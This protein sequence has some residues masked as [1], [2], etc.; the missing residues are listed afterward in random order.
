MV[1][2]NRPQMPREPGPSPALEQRFQRMMPMEPVFQRR[3]MEP[4]ATPPATATPAAAASETAEGET[5]ATAEPE[6]PAEGDVE[7]GT[8]A[9]EAETQ[10]TAAAVEEITPVGEVIDFP[11]VAPPT[12]AAK[13]A[14][15]PPPKLAPYRAPDLTAIR[16]P[17]L[18]GPPAATMA[19]APEVLR[20]TG[21]TPS[22]HHANI[23]T[24]LFRV[25]E[26]AR[27][28]QR[29]MVQSIDS[30]ATGARWSIEAM[31]G[32]VDAIV[33]AC[34]ASV[35][36]AS[37]AALAEVERVVAA[38]KAD[39]MAQTTSGQAAM[40]ERA[41]AVRA[42]VITSLTQNGASK[43][44][45]AH[46][47]LVA[48]YDS[49]ADQAATRLPPMATGQKP[50]PLPGG[51][52]ATPDKAAPA[53]AGAAPSTTYAA[54]GVKVAAKVPTAPA[55]DSDLAYRTAYLNIPK[56][57]IIQPTAKELTAAWLKAAKARAETYK[58]ADNHNRFVIAAL[59]LVAPTAEGMNQDHEAF[60]KT[61]DDEAK[62]SGI[63]MTDAQA[64]AI[65]GIDTTLRGPRSVVNFF[66]PGNPDSMPFKIN[67]GLRQTGDKIKAAL[68]QQGLEVESG[69]RAGIA[70]MAEAYP[71]VLARLEE[72]LAGDDL[73]DER[74]FTPRVLQAA[75]S[76]IALHDGQIGQVRGN[77]DATLRQVR[78]SFQGQVRGLWGAVDDAQAGILEQKL[79]AVFHFVLAK[80]LYTGT[81]GTDLQASL[82]M[83]AGYAET[84]ARAM[85]APVAA[86]GAAGSV[87]QQKAAD[88]FNAQLGGEWEG[89]LASVARLG[90]ELGAD[91]EAA[92][93]AK[94]PFA[95][96]EVD[97][98][99]DMHR[100]IREISAALKAP[101]TKRTAIASAVSVLA[102]P[103][104]G[105]LS[106][107]AGIF[108]SWSAYDNLPKVSD[109]TKALAMPDFGPVALNAEATLIGESETP[110]Q[111]VEKYM[112]DSS[113]EKSSLLK[114]F[115][116]N[117]AKVAEGKQETITKADRLFGI[118]DDAVAAMAASF[119]PAQL[120]LLSDA[121]REAM[122]ASV[123]SNL[124]GVQ[125]KVTQAFLDGKPARAAAIRILDDLDQA[126]RK[127]DQGLAGF[128]AQMDARIAADLRRGD[129]GYLSAEA[130]RTQTEAVYLEL[131]QLIPPPG[132]QERAGDLPAPTDP[133]PSA[134]TRAA[135][136]ADARQRF[137][138]HATRDYA[139]LNTSSI[140]L[141]MN[142][143]GF[144]MAGALL[145]PVLPAGVGSGLMM[146]TGASDLSAL[147]TGS[148]SDDYLTQKLLAEGL[149]GGGG[150]KPLQVSDTRRL[151]GAV[152]LDRM[153]D[154]TAAMLTDYALNGAQSETVREAQAQQAL[155]LA[156]RRPLGT[157]ESDV[158]RFNQLLGSHGVS[159]AKARLQDAQEK[160]D[161]AAVEAARETL[162]V[163][164]AKH[165][166]FLARVAARAEGRPPPENPGEDEIAAARQSL[167]NR[168]NR[169]SAGYDSGLSGAGD[170]I[171]YRG[172]IDLATGLR[173]AT[174]GLGTANALQSE[175]MANRTRREMERHFTSA[176]AIEDDTTLHELGVG[177]GFWDFK[178][179]S[180]DEAFELYIQSRGIPETDSD[181]AE[182]ATMRA[183]H[184]LAGGTGPFA[185]LLMAGSEQKRYLT[186]QE[187][188]VA[189]R[190]A[191]A[192][193]ANSDPE[194]PVPAWILA[195]PPDRYFDANGEMLPEIR[196]HS[197]NRHGEF[198]G[199]GPSM[200][201][202]S[203]KV[204]VG[205]KAYADEIER[206]ESF[207]TGVITAAAIVASIVLMFIPGVNLV[208]AGI[209]VAVL[210]GAA[211]I[212]V[213][214]GMRGGRYGWEEAA[215]D[216]ART[217]IEAA[218]AGAGGAMGG[219]LRT[220]AMVMGRLARVG[221]SLNRSFGRV[222][223][224]LVR[225]GMMG[226]ASG[227]AHKALDDR[228]WTNGIGE[229]L[230][231]LFS[232]GLQG[233]VIGAVTGGLSEGVSVGSLRLLTPGLAGTEAS[234][235]ARVGA[236]LG[237]RG[238]NVVQEALSGLTGL[239]SGEGMRFLVDVTSGSERASWERFFARIGPAA[240]RDM[241][242][243]AGRA[244]AQKHMR[245]LYHAELARVQASGRP[246]H[247]SEARFLRRLAI[248]AGVESYG[249]GHADSE[250]GPGGAPGPRRSAL[251]AFTV[252][253]VA[254]RSILS[255]MPP[256][257]AAKMSTLPLEHLQAFARMRQTGVAGSPAD[258][259]ALH[260]AI[261]NATPGVV[262]EALGREMLALSQQDRH[263]AAARVKAEAVSARQQAALRRDLLSDLPAATRRH[264]QDHP[265]DAL[266]T[267]PPDLRQ[268]ARALI[269]D[270]DPDGTGV[271][272]LVARAGEVGEA[273]ARQLADLVAARPV[274]EAAAR[275]AAADRRRA[276]AELLP[277]RMHGA[278][279][280][281]PDKDIAFLHRSLT[282]APTPKALTHLEKMLTR[283]LPSEDVQAVLHE[284]TTRHQA[285][286]LAVEAADRAALH[287]RRIA[288]MDH[289]P[290]ADRAL[291]AHLSEDALLELRVA[292]ALGKPLDPTRRAAILARALQDAP[293]L[294]PAALTAAI[295][296]TTAAK[297][298]AR[299]FF[300][301]FR[302]RRALLRQVP[303]AMLPL[304]R[305]T[306]ILTLTDAAFA[307]LVR[308]HPEAVTG[309]GD[310]AATLRLGGQVV[311][312]VRA[313]T[314][315]LALREEG[316]HVLQLHDPAWSS[317]L[318]GLDEARLA[319]W[320]LL[321]VAERLAL[322]RSVT[323]AEIDAHRAMIPVLEAELA[324]AW[325]SR[326]KTRL[327]A[328]LARVRDRLLAL[329]VR[330]GTL[331]AITP[332]HRLALETGLTALPHWLIQP[333]RLFNA[334]AGKNLTEA[335]VVAWMASKGLGPVPVAPPTL[336]PPA[337]KT[338]RPAPQPLPAK[339][340]KS[341][342]WDRWRQ[343][344]VDTVQSTGRPAAAS[345]RQRLEIDAF[346][347]QVSGLPPEG[348]NAVL[349]LLT[350]AYPISGK[351]TA[352]AGPTRGRL[353]IL[354]LH[355]S[356]FLTEM[357][358]SPGTPG[359]SDSHQRLIAL[360]V[361]RMGDEFHRSGHAYADAAS[362]RE[363]AGSYLAMIRQ[364][365]QIAPDSLAEAT[366]QAVGRKVLVEVRRRPH[367]TDT[368]RRNV[369]Q[370]SRMLEFLEA[371]SGVSS[372][373]GVEL[374]MARVA[375]SLLQIAVPSY[376][377]AGFL[378]GLPAD[379][380]K[381]FRAR[382]DPND[383]PEVF[384]R[385]DDVAI[386]ANKYGEWRP[387]ND[388]VSVPRRKGEVASHH[389]NW[390]GRFGEVMVDHWATK[391]NGWVRV[392]PSP[393]NGPMTMNDAF[394]GANAIDAIY[395][396]PKVSPRVYIVID[397][398]ALGATLGKVQ[399]GK[400]KQMSKTWIIDRLPNTDLTL[401]Q[402]QMIEDQLT[403]GNPR[404]TQ[405]GWVVKVG[406]GG[407]IKVVAID[408]K[409]DPI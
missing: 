355:R 30:L 243:A 157:S 239:V 339:A 125:L 60:Q 175:V 140:G 138:R 142:S 55:D 310:H 211:T 250:A 301:R 255:T 48:A 121:Q 189:D 388:M 112:S 223:G 88:H 260:H 87:I 392:D 370:R 206:M 161:S 381:H 212:A 120:S 53:A 361:R 144:G 334:D 407:Q 92:G 1:L 377:T 195:L 82:A 32:R 259:A 111:R 307:A 296:R 402:Q 139:Q 274:A 266:L 304:V 58:S 323:E 397:V 28:A 336:A 31:A 123:R 43:I 7:T 106:L 282:G 391:Q 19:R 186:D 132:V 20:R 389:S 210:A 84:T 171:I 209:I 360:L 328:D 303:A 168:I 363:M 130:I 333:P 179:N 14:P 40:G 257:L 290:E 150:A 134:D 352:T 200:A 272:A 62:A 208:V 349:H 149:A 383:P 137:A 353:L 366:L 278:L 228:I 316:L 348:Q 237:T 184:Q 80:S 246:I 376:L 309:Q 163:E 12:A 276:V 45:E 233:G 52:P 165:G 325:L 262:A 13:S 15:L 131:G 94:K 379:M 192:L 93:D 214:A 221:A 283:H 110:Q 109:A 77:V 159:L 36:A 69:F 275:A 35:S 83:V 96:I 313:G 279:A 387:V 194:N 67:R 2:K 153:S 101:N 156:E 374:R 33:N 104:T 79:K 247:P 145:S 108:A 178:E 335:E 24:A 201:M 71:D 327:Q 203:A 242:S 188:A 78:D 300:E 39:I 117:A 99:A 358:L 396:D 75:V 298:P 170:D 320:H 217:A 373:P 341:A 113:T 230:S 249:R 127:G 405:T 264:L 141:D 321:S 155:G 4:E 180:G 148:S 38:Q 89:Y 312:V 72:M 6:K 330:Q 10:P 338:A 54:E 291:L 185:M 64:S 248:S 103:F 324:G 232:A 8:S 326:S 261:A 102:A 98:V 187:Q 314:D 364:V 73:L 5:G 122:A 199:D 351:P 207:F 26:V 271:A 365:R 273:M 167:A 286:R 11:P 162:K 154:D 173:V 302:Q 193:K 265:V 66:T 17:I 213:K 46:T 288:Q 369:V 219:A 258:R 215:T 158:V 118:N 331:D 367:A 372:G 202:L 224:A 401:A 147:M 174:D 408:W 356:G 285:Q 337:K 280:A 135:Q 240:L 318:A 216:V 404:M 244:G 59:G 345:T 177:A 25:T 3:T 22:Q 253:L 347:T 85:L 299:P 166:R 100:R 197:V 263:D 368:T 344:Y 136:V 357:A 218:T 50:A 115:S 220:E 289:V 44:T 152:A 37:L 27:T 191:V 9:P 164:E 343:H 86:A 317:R 231:T 251:D 42:Q 380:P 292:Q 252:D 236:R 182:L 371:A 68:M 49:A 375:A 61:L 176:Q 306:P 181:H 406:A 322:T 293:H 105:G 57:R 226:T 340:P 234:Q 51:T 128:T 222:G 270:G 315:A 238:R 18:R 241:L 41:A 95:V 74:I 116:K 350:T 47:T 281:L 16:A 311:V 23:Q 297:A 107:G 400:I 205:V 409:G 385:H 342:T 65:R 204:D 346:F 160:G 76:L 190:V 235:L 97:H 382:R 81:F 294:D 354:A 329:E 287:S 308:A 332:A 277:E 386:I 390:V 172:A 305:Q 146:V 398:K 21:N 254:A 183:R 114:L 196:R 70:Q 359:H 399:G 395:Y 295:A 29:D 229:G 143:L 119:S 319:Q 56:A 126:R 403:K 90:A 169:L 393:R 256:H 384:R 129:K 245:G 378:N 394:R 227:L 269:R 225:E 198:Y 63:K 34:T 133:T 91:K 268:A 267:L 284:A 362:L 151:V 124:S